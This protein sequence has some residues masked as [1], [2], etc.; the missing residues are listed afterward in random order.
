MLDRSPGSRQHNEN[1][2]EEVFIMLNTPSV[3]RVM[4]NFELVYENVSECMYIRKHLLF[5]RPHPSYS[6]EG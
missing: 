5:L 2:K 3:D 6:S 1:V 4:F